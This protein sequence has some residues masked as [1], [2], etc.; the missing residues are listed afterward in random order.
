[1]AW[2]RKG[3]LVGSW[4][5]D[6]HGRVRTRSSLNLAPPSG[7]RSNRCGPTLAVLLRRVADDAPCICTPG[8]LMGETPHTQKNKTPAPD[9][10]RAAGDWSRAGI[11]DGAAVLGR[12]EGGWLGV[13]LAPGI[14]GVLQAW[15]KGSGPVGQCGIGGPGWPGV[16]TRV[17]SVYCTCGIDQAGP[18]VVA[19]SISTAGLGAMS[20]GRVRER[21][22]GTMRSARSRRGK[23][24]SQGEGPANWV[25]VPSMVRRPVG[26]SVTRA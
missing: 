17:P 12:E 10:G 20:T 11:W 16:D 14:S 24:R 26:S 21:I 19:Q 22:L 23:L 6:Q 8:L 25:A 2:G 3:R 5:V 1:M 9:G 18:G 13:N 15:G 4:W 7:R